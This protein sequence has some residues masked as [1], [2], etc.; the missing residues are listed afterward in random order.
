MT[1][2]P[3]LMTV[4]ELRMYLKCS[5]ANA[6]ALVKSRDFPSF[7]VGNSYRVRKNDFIEWVN[8]QKIEGK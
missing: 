5:N 2:L 3:E 4:K 1:N 7:K 8:N 6:Y